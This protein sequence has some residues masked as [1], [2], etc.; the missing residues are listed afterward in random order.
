MP[1]SRLT[2]RSGPDSSP[3]RTRR[4]VP[5]SRVFARP[6]IFGKAA[7]P[8]RDDLFRKPVPERL[9]TEPPS[10]C[11]SPRRLAISRDSSSDYNRPKLGDRR[12]HLAYRKFVRPLRS[13]SPF[14]DRSPS[15]SP[16]SP[17]AGNR[18]A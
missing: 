13:E 7:P 18:L 11:P 8:R 5:C 9:I 16:L 10:T 1:A 12:P 2:D 17:T 3:D 4:L 14:T 15:C 6:S